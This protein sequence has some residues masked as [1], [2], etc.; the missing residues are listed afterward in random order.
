[1]GSWEVK[2]EIIS[3]HLP[4]NQ[5]TDGLEGSQGSF[6]SND[7]Y[8]QMNQLDESIRLFLLLFSKNAAVTL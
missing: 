8:G 6:T 1:M 3:D 2:L 4:S 7:E 5:P